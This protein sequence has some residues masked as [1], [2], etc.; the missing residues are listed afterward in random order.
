MRSRYAAFALDDPA[1]L[2]RSWHPSTRPRQLVLDPRQVWTGLTVLAS[3]GGLFDLDGEVSFQARYR[4]DG[5]AGSVE[6]RSRFVREQ[7][8]WR[9]V[10][11]QAP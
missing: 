4:L 10:G 5:V 1:W 7:Q 8:A 11:P 6:E 3:R 2:L 9:Y